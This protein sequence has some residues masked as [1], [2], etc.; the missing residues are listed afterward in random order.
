MIKVITAP[1]RVNFTKNSIKVF[2]AGGIQKCPMWQDRII[3]NF[4]NVEMESDV[5]VYLMNPRRPNFPINEPSAA[6]EQIRWEFEMLEKC[7]VFSMYF[8]NTLESDQPICF[9]EL[10]RNIER[11]KKRFPLDWYERIVVTCEKGFSRWKDV[12]IQTSLATDDE[13]VVNLVENDVELKEHTRGILCAI[14]SVKLIETG[15]F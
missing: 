7:D 6:E 15:L 14:A 10:G 3:K 9:Y 1:E 11:M 2:L 8:A 5:D 4:T 13:V 12:D